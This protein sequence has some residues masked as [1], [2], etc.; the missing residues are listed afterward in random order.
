MENKNDFT[1]MNFYMEFADKLLPYVKDRQ[2]LIKKIKSVYNAI[3]MN[4][5]KLEKDGNVVDIDP[6][7][8]FGLFNK[9]IT[10]VNRITIIQGFAN[11]FSVISPVP[12]SFDGIPVLNPLKSTFYHFIDDRKDGDIENLWQVFISALEYSKTHSENSRNEFIRTYNAALL[13]KSVKWNLT[14]ALYWVRPYEYIN[15]DSCNRGFICDTQNMPEDFINDLGKLNDVPT[16]EKYL[17][18]IENCRSILAKSNYRYKNFP[19][20]SYCAWRNS[21]KTNPPEPPPKVITE[22][23]VR[24]WL[25]APGH[26][27][28]KWEEFYNSGIIAIGWGE[29]GNLKNFLS[30]NE[31]KQKMKECIDPSRSYKNDAHATWQFANEMNIGDIV[32]V[33]KGMHKIIGRGVVASNYEFEPS[34]DDN[35]NNIRQIKWTHS[36]EW[37]YPCSGQ[38]A[39]KALTDITSYTGYVEELSALFDEDVDLDDPDSGYST[40][41]K[42]DFLNDVYMSEDNYTTLTNLLK[43]KKN[44]ILQGAPGVGKTFVAERLAYSIMEVKDSSRVKMVQFHQ[45]YSYEDFI[46]GFRPTSTGNGFEIKK[47]PFYKFCKDA[48]S[49]SDND[50]FFIIDEINRGNLSKI[51]GELFMLIENDKRGIQL[52]LLYENEQ[53]F[54]PKN[55]YIIGM[56][57]TADRSLAMLDYAL[58]RRFAFFEISP[59]FDTEGFRRYC[60]GKNNDKLNKLI[61]VVK[62]LNKAIENDSSLGKG[63]RIGHSYFCTEYEIDDMRLNSIVSYEIIPLLEEYWFDEPNNVKHWGQLLHEAI[64]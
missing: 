27:A 10:N 38:A 13:Q 29:I 22:K 23:A 57:N 45:S 41:N 61:D 39:M 42:K 11:E 6:F 26:N 34:R 19:E 44:V 55:V 12:N 35:Y 21:Q 16:A 7:T 30:K 63:F 8:V 50:Y 24:Y 52:Q 14:M 64:Q 28:S 46:M 36:G 5:P 18:I 33:K 54:I 3:N 48:E 1:W 37:D 32:F 58:R 9:G 49:D 15:L 20:L 17:E 40:Y 47:G 4:L 62:E 59:A 56:M 51:F 43:Y 31:M 2:S 25:Y 53:F 60:Q